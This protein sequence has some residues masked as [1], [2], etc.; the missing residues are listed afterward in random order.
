LSTHIF[1]ERPRCDLL[2]NHIFGW[3]SYFWRKLFYVEI[4]QFSPFCKTGQLQHKIFFFENM[5]I[6]QKCDFWTD[7]IEAFR[8]ICGLTKFTQKL[9]EIQRFEISRNFAKFRKISQIPYQNEQKKW[10][11]KLET[12]KC[13]FRNLA[14]TEFKKNFHDEF[15]SNCGKNKKKIIWGGNF[16][17]FNRFKSSTWVCCVCLCV[18]VRLCVS[19][20]ST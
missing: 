20:S 8:E 9:R 18:S 11:L 7:H 4:V 14:T 1:L 2:K 16:L 15:S 6:T 5:K 13:N 10:S 17:F 12:Q 3:F 19:V